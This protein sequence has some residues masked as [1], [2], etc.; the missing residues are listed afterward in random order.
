VKK[1]LLIICIFIFSVNLQAGDKLIRRS[2]ANVKIM[3]KIVPISLKF[4]DNRVNFSIAL[5]NDNK[6]V[7]ILVPNNKSKNKKEYFKALTISIRWFLKNWKIGKLKYKFVAFVLQGDF[8]K[9]PYLFVISSNN[10]RLLDNR[11]FGDKDLLAFNKSLV[12]PL[13]LI[14]R[15]GKFISEGKEN[16]AI[17]KDYSKFLEKFDISPLIEGVIEAWYKKKKIK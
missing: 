15:R 2:L 6:T 1:S 4:Y 13:K 9:Y 14:L 3:N 12:Y 7:A 11:D 16:I 10:L 8:K 17:K 5:L